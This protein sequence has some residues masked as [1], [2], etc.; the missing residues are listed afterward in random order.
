MQPGVNDTPAKFRQAQG[1]HHMQNAAIQNHNEF[2]EKQGNAVR[3]AAKNGLRQG[4]EG[5]D[6]F[7]AS[8]KGGLD[9]IFASSSILTKG[10][11]ELAAKSFE[12]AKANAELTLEFAG[13]LSK[14]KTLSDVVA[15]P[16]A[17]ANKQF[18]ALS[19]QAKDISSLAR[20]IADE[21]FKP[22]QS[23]IEIAAKR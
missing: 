13:A 4:Q 12:A 11:N 22:L 18:Q 1:F 20:K 23:Q 5:L 10:W 15:L 14:A 3:E 7:N 19:S 21:A 16:S 17:H 6:K 2:V 8:A 9:A